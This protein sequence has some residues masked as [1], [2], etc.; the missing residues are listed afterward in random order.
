MVAVSVM[1]ARAK[2]LCPRPITRAPK[3]QHTRSITF[4][5]VHSVRPC[6]R[7]RLWYRRSYTS[8]ATSNTWPE[9]TGSVS[10]WQPITV[11]TA[12]HDIIHVV[13]QFHAIK[14]QSRA[15]RKIFEGNSMLIHSLAVC[16]S[17]N[18]VRRQ[19]NSVLNIVSIHLSP[20]N[21]PTINQTIENEV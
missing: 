5:H 14:T 3:S 8:T 16:F 21:R 6:D 11:K 17:L 20:H 7:S 13:A 19:S 9:S 2:L 1:H 4:D 12:A 15:S 18:Q 10:K